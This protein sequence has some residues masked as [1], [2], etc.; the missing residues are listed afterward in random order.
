MTGDRANALANLEKSVELNPK[1]PFALKPLGQMYYNSAYF[2]IAVSYF[3]KAIEIEPNYLAARYALAQTYEKRNEPGLASVEYSN[4]IRLNSNLARF[5]QRSSYE[6]AL[7]SINITE[8]Y[9]S[10]GLVYMRIGDFNKAIHWFDRALESNIN[11]AAAHSN[12]ASV[13]F[14]KKYYSMAIEQAEF[15]I[16]CAPDEPLHVRNLALIYKA[17]GNTGKVKELEQKIKN[18]TSKRL[19]QPQMNTGEHR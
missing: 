7:L 12:I 5:E 4:I 17:L 14:Y 8:V 19:L 2:N 18:M 6:R 16:K 3:S 1:N 9:N 11:D 10:L 15:A 13:Y